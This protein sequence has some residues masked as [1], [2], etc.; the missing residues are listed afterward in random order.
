MALDMS[1]DKVYPDLYH[2]LKLCII[3][4]RGIHDISG[5][6][7]NPKLA[8]NKDMEF[9]N[10]HIQLTLNQD[11]VEQEIKIFLEEFDIVIIENNLMIHLTRDCQVIE[12]GNHYILL[13][14]NLK[15]N[16][17]I[18]SIT[19]YCKFKQNY[20]EM[21]QDTDKITITYSKYFMQDKNPFNTYMI[22][23][24]NYS[25]IYISSKDYNIYDKQIQDLPYS[26]DNTIKTKPKLVPDACIIC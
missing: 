8:R 16:N 12:T 23:G 22:D 5:L 4:Q 11:K 3:E 19:F 2:F 13:S 17:V 10:K 20:N 18:N 9:L 7:K 14:F 15:K 1:I 21:P 26:F 6:D 25:K 24:K